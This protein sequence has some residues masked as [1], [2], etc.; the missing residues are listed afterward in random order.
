MSTE[1]KA[2]RGKKPSV[3]RL[4]AR[5]WRDYFGVEME[6][7]AKGET[8]F[9][10]GT[11]ANES[12]AYR[13]CLENWNEKVEADLAP[14]SPA[15]RQGAPL[16]EPKPF[17]G[18]MPGV[19]SHPIWPGYEYSCSLVAI[20]DRVTCA[21]YG[22]GLTPE[23]A[24]A[25]AIAD[26]NKKVEELGP[27]PVA[28]S[29]AGQDAVGLPAGSRTHTPLPWSVADTGFGKGHAPG[30]FSEGCPY[31]HVVVMDSADSEGGVLGLTRAEALGNAHL[32]VTAV[33][34]HGA[35]VAAAEKARTFLY[36]DTM[37]DLEG[38]D[39][40]AVMEALDAALALVGAES[41]AGSPSVS[42]PSAEREGGADGDD[43]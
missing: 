28:A 24:E 35:L 33:N 37:W 32:I 38:N 21:G 26:W 13:A 39:Q 12:E 11:G 4:P 14:S 23:A 36:G 16:T 27:E 1:P 7:T 8:C 25:D 17:R 42:R 20:V 31:S 2:F 40:I 15:P 43:R 10:K 41:P 30:I 9:A 6:A 3:T 22:R 29:Q 18:V 5:P 19:D 34:S